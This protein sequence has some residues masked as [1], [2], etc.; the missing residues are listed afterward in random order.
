DGIRDFH[1]T[2]VQTCA[3]P[4]LARRLTL[5]T[6]LIVLV[7]FA[8]IYLVVNY[9]VVESIDRELKLETDKH[10]GQIFIVNG[11][12]RFVHKDEWLEQRSEERREG[13]GGKSQMSPVR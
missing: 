3:L 12:I 13:K 6:A 11:E 1:V 7:V 5:V 9:T 8:I 2:G 10:V 4:I